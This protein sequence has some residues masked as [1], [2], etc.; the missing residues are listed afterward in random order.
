MIRELDSQQIVAVSGGFS[1]FKSFKNNTIATL[2]GAVGGKGAQAA[3]LR[4][5]LSAAR[6]AAV[7]GAAGIVIGIAVGVGLEYMS[8]RGGG[9]ECEPG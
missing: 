2:S 7:G 1:L 6:G 8:S 5:G 3:A 9:D 4:I